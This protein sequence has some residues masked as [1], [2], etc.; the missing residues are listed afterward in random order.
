MIKVIHLLNHL[1]KIDRDIHE[2]EEL[3]SKLQI[4][5]SYTPRVQESLDTEKKHLQELQGLIAGLPVHSPDPLI[6]RDMEQ[7]LGATIG[8]AAVQPPQRTTATE[9]QPKLEIIVPA[10]SSQKQKT[11]STPIRS[12]RSTR[13]RNDKNSGDSPADFEKNAA[14]PA[15][16]NTAA[17]STKPAFRWKFVQE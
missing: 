1:E 12:N 13:A 16:N 2:L 11:G 7:F 14:A 9:R 6:L 17:S 5:R 3:R 4:D 15:A 10:Q 8:T